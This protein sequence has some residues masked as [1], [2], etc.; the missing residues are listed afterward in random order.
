MLGYLFIC[1]FI[2]VTNSIIF[3]GK[4]QTAKRIIKV[5]VSLR[6]GYFWIRHYPY[7]SLTFTRHNI[8]ADNLRFIS[9]FGSF[10]RILLSLSLSLSIPF[11]FLFG[12]SNGRFRP[13]SLKEVALFSSLARIVTFYLLHKH[14]YRLFDPYPSPPTSTG[15]V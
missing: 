3:W 15:W 9:R 5:I 12:V 14:F 7:N 6:K 2:W 1:C 10:T 13:C 8:L 11:T 4:R